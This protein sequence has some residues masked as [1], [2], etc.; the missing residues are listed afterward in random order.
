MKNVVVIGAGIA[1]LAT[2][3]RLQCAGYQVQVYEANASPGG[4]LSELQIGRYRFDAGPSLFTM[5]QY[6]EE[7]FAISGKPIYEYFSY[8]RKEIVCEY[9]FD[10]LTRFTAFGNLEAYCKEAEKAFGI[11]PATLKKYFA[12]SQMKFERTRSLFLENSLH[13]LATYLNK[14]TLQA[15]ASLSSLSLFSTLHTFNTAKLN[16]QYLVQL[17]DRYATYNGSSPYQTPAIMSMIPHLEQH[18]G[19]YV[20]KGGMISIT[21][22]LYQLALDL[23]VQF[24][25]NTKVSQISIANKVADGIVVNER[26][27]PADIVV[28]NMDIM[29]TYRYLLPSQKAPE[30]ILSQER[31]SSAIIFYWG[32]RHSFEQLNLHNI[33]FSKDYQAEF[34]SIFSSQTVADDITVYVNISSKDE[35]ADA[36]EG[37]ENWFVMVNAPANVGQDWDEIIQRTRK[38]IL[39][40]LSKQLQTNLEDFIECEAIL[41]P[42]SIEAKTQSAQGALYGS[43]SNNRYAAFLRHPNFSRKIKNLYFC[44]GSVH[45]GG[46]IPLCLLSAKI[47]AALITKASV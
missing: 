41:D 8:K 6:I 39:S 36:P 9:F 44:G 32:I 13:K 3:I 2:A 17:F 16:N 21:N 35:L 4:K 23:G 43:A 30:K 24:N 19:T 34:A 20:P 18:F 47:T 14:E 5:P 38:N 28:S 25:F 40:K 10:D 26:K 33:F 31:S 29:P 27:I 11:A 1:G 12:N 45:P 15:L 42:R 22:S 7:L 46:G 37:C